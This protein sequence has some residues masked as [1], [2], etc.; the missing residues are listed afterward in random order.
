MT[1]RCELPWHSGLAVDRTD[2][3]GEGSHAETSSLQKLSWDLGEI[4]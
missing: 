4:F 1:F 2:D 3:I